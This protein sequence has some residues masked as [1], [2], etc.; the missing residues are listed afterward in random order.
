M[1]AERAVT[2]DLDPGESSG[3]TS[4]LDARADARLETLEALLGAIVRDGR[5][6]DYLRRAR[7][8]ENLVRIADKGAPEAHPNGFSCVSIASTQTR[9]RL[10]LHL[11]T[12]PVR[13]ADIHT[14]RWNFASRLLAGSLRTKSYRADSGAGEHVQFACSR[15]AAREY[16]F[17]RVGPCRVLQVEERT[18]REGDAYGQQWQALHTVDTGELPAATVVLQGSDVADWS[19]VITRDDAKSSSGMP[20]V[21]LTTDQIRE[22]IDIALAGLPG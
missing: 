10:R 7:T 9:W 19:T 21:P 15:N 3:L 8:D 16:V 5:L 2:H 14:H 4:L 13:Q 6:R 12:C 17:E 20:V 18:Y 22:V 11:W 1:C